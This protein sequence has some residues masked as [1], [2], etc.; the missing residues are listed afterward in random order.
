[1][2]QDAWNANQYLI[3]AVVA[4][5]RVGVN[6]TYPSMVSYIC[7][8]LYLYASLRNP[9]SLQCD[10]GQRRPDVLVLQLFHDGTGIFHDGAIGPPLGHA[11]ANIHRLKSVR[12]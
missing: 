6:L 9:S 2:L 1:M 8:P 11:A 4:I 12:L 10:Q 7:H 3:T 5:C